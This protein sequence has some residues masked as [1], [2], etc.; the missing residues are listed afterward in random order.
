MWN[1]VRK[2]TT[3]PGITASSGTGSAARRCSLA[4]RGT[5][6]PGALMHIGYES[7]AIEALRIGAAEMIRSADKLSGRAHN[8]STAIIGA[9]GSAR[10][11][12]AASDHRG[13]QKQEQPGKVR[14]VWSY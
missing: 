9:F 11:A 5:S 4:L 8:R 3:S 14:Q 2:N 10:D 13:K 7:A 1:L 6:Q 12:A